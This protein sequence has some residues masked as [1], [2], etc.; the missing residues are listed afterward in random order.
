MSKPDI[1]TERFVCR[2]CIQDRGLQEV[3]DKY[4][5]KQKCSYCNA[6]KSV[7]LE[8]V[9]GRMRSSI[10]TVYGSLEYNSTND[11]NIPEDHFQIDEVMNRLGFRISNEDL[12]QDI[13]TA[14]KDDFFTED[15]EN[16]YL[17]SVRREAWRDFTILVKHSRRY[18]FST[19]GES[20]G[21]ELDEL[22]WSPNN[23]LRNIGKLVQDMG[24]LVQIKP[25]AS[26]WRVRLHDSEKKMEMPKDYTS[27]PTQYAKYSNRMSP[28]GVPM[29]YGTDDFETAVLETTNPEQ[30][31]TNK[32]VS[33]IQ[34]AAKRILSILDLTNLPEDGSF[35][36]DWDLMKRIGVGFLSS[37]VQDVS[38]PIKKDG[39]EH[40]EYVPTQVFT[41]FVRHDM[42]EYERIDGIKYRS[43]KNGRGCYVLFV[44]QDECL[45]DPSGHGNKQIL[46]AI[47]ASHQTASCKWCLPTDKT[48]GT[49]TR[50][51]WRPLPDAGSK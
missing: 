47:P 2:K 3:V 9:I 18:T 38:K 22:M 32:V 40:I 15:R 27:P 39:M 12:Q 29:F 50:T 8:Y 28:A 21:P 5:D 10:G 13:E 51:N 17:R 41:E 25:G 23:V 30:D 44:E 45:P 19:Y 6:R 42:T 49:K 33:G 26:F 24:L 20:L 1:L 7:C 46:E 35:F 4:A 14:F 48:S 16:S 11:G 37:F 36:N 34:F 43:S 31:T